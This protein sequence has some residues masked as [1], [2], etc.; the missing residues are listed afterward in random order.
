LE[1]SRKSNMERKILYGE[2]KAMHDHDLLVIVCTKV[3]TLE[4]HFTNHLKHH[5]AITLAATTATFMGLS[6]FIVGVILLFVKFGVS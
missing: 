6:S 3:D 2:Y 5:W 4:K 1:G